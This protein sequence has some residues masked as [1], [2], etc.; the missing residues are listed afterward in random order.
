MKHVV[1]RNPFLTGFEYGTLRTFEDT[2]C[3]ITQGELIELPQGG[4]ISKVNSNFPFSTWKNK[5][6]GLSS[7]TELK[8]DGDILW[9]ILMGPE[10]YYLDIL[11]L[12]QKS[13]QCKILYLFDTLPQQYNLI[14]Q[15]IDMN[16]WDL[17]ITSF[18]DAI[19][20]LEKITNRK[21]ICVE[22]GIP[23]N[24]F[25]EVDFVHKVIPFSIYGRTSQ[26][27][28]E[29]IY[30]FCLVNDLYLDTSLCA[31]PKINISS[32]TLY[33]QYCWHLTHSV[34]TLSLPVEITSPQR[35]GHL[36]PITCRWFEACAAGTSVI[37]LP[38]ANTYF[39]KYFPA[40]MVL[41]LHPAWS[42]N[43]IWKTLEELWVN[44]EEHNLHAQ[45]IRS[46]YLESIS[47]ENRTNRII[48]QVIN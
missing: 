8:I 35:A 1:L 46:Q 40:S 2:V 5:F 17:L 7:K 3:K 30:E 15:I 12:T 33:K 4:N 41:E 44:R 11:K 18:N 42:K 26:K 37:G 16:T 43:K 19:P 24:Y 9:L 39:N 21:W 13:W 31:Q 45:N 48:Q 28:V 25:P 47:W 36:S 34:F 38:P 6:R 10:N 29:I 23:L 20:D 22:Q 14:K 32:E 27:L